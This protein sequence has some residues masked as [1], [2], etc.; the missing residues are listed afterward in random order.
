MF[1]SKQSVHF[2]SDLSHQSGAQLLHW[3]FLAFHAKLKYTLFYLIDVP[4]H[5]CTFFFLNVHNGFITKK[6]FGLGT[7]C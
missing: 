2:S 6:G 5:G 3:M 1:N 7:R 4:G